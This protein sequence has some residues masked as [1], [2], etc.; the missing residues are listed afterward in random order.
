MKRLLPGFQLSCEQ[1]ADEEL[2]EKLSVVIRRDFPI[3]T[4]V[5]HPV[6]DLCLCW[7]VVKQSFIPYH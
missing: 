4:F 2:C 5:C 6:A 1:K 7:G 3:I